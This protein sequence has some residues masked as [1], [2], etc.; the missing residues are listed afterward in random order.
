MYSCC[1]LR[2]AAAWAVLLMSGSEHPR[3]I[4]SDTACSA[5][6]GSEAAS[7]LATTRVTRGCHCKATAITLIQGEHK[8]TRETCCWDLH[9]LQRNNTSYWHCD[10]QHFRTKCKCTT[11]WALIA[12]MSAKKSVW[13]MPCRPHYTMTKNPEHGIYM[14]MHIWVHC[15]SWTTCAICRTCKDY[16]RRECLLPPFWHR[17]CCF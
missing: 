2:F 6:P 7:S 13:L 1:T 12:F 10:F 17:R 14:H 15:V 8:Q 11:A 16:W 3:L 5:G 9:D 4:M